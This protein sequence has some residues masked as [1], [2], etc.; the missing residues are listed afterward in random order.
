MQRKD[1]DYGEATTKKQ[2]ITA[3]F[4]S[5]IWFSVFVMLASSFIIDHSFYFTLE[6]KT[7]AKGKEFLAS[8]PSSSKVNFVKDQNLKTYLNKYCKL[9]KIYGCMISNSRRWSTWCPLSYSSDSLSVPYLPQS[10]NTRYCCS[11]M[12]LPHWWRWNLS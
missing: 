4:F 10:E 11:H 6:L 2:T 8:S 9:I 3:I 12:P 1:G 7:P 5:Y